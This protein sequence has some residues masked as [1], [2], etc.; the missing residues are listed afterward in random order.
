MKININKEIQRNEV[1]LKALLTMCA[2]QVCQKDLS[3]RLCFLHQPL[4]EFLTVQADHVKMSH[5]GEA[6][7]LFGQSTEQLHLLR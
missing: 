2:N 7:D 1:L 4:F 5:Q 6:G 3:K